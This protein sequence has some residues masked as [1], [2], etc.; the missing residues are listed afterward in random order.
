MGRRIIEDQVADEVVGGSIIFTED[1]KYCGLNCTNQCKV[2]NYDACIKFISDN[3]EDMKEGE[4][5][6]QMCSLGYLTK[7]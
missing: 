3:Y 7:L 1:H 6:K 4:M 2:N 5:L